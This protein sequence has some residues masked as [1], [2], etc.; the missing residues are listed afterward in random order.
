MECDFVG[1]DFDWKIAPNRLFSRLRRSMG[2][3]FGLESR[4]VRRI[5]FAKSGSFWSTPWHYYELVL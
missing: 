2:R 1:G 3:R 4:A 5:F